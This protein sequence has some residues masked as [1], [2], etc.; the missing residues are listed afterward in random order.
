MILFVNACVR[1]DSRTL[2]IAKH[3][4]SLFED[5]N[6]EE[7]VLEDIKFPIVDE[8]FIELRDRLKRENKIDNKIF[9]LGRQFQMADY[10]VIAAPYWDLSFPASLKQYIEQINVLNI[11]FKYDD[12]GNPEG[13]CNAKKLYYVSTAGGYY[14][15][16]DYSYGYIKDLCHTFYGIK[17]TE[18]IFVKGLDII[19]NDSNKIVEDCIKN[20][21]L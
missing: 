2:R 16:M 15:N 4:L 6:I 3:L 9:D 20:I 7:V 21:K 1:K 5:K 8:E 11:T 19:G 17:D 13:L 18:L 14:D 10:I 12:K